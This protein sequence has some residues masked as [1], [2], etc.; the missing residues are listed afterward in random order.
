M[1]HTAAAAA[2]MVG[3]GLMPSAAEAFCGHYVGGDLTNAESQMIVS[4]EGRRTVLTMANDVQGDLTDFGLIVPVPP[5]VTAEDISVVDPAVLDA[6]DV[7]SAPRLVSYS[8]D[9]IAWVPDGE[10]GWDASAP[11][12]PSS[13]V[14]C[15]GGGSTTS[16]TTIQHDTG[17]S[18]DS[19]GG[20][21]EGGGLGE[22]TLEE[23]LR[24]ERFTVG[25]YD[26]AVVEASGS[27]GLSAWLTEAGFALTDEAQVL[28][29]D[30]IAEEM[31]FLVA[32]VSLD[33]LPADRPWLSPLQIRYEADVVSIPIRLGTLS[34]AGVQD[35]LIYTLSGTG[36][37]G[38]STYPEFSV[39]HECLL[40]PVT[41][42]GEFI[43]EQ[44]DIALGYTDTSEGDTGAEPDPEPRAGAGYVTEYGWG[45]GKCDPCP[46]E[47]GV[48]EDVL[49]TLG[50][51]GGVES[52]WVT[53][54]HMRYR[55]EDITADLVLYE[56]GL[57]SLMQLRYVDYAHELEDYWPVCGEG[58][59][60]DPG[61]CQPPD[62]P[63]P[64]YE[65]V[66]DE[67]DRYYDEDDYDEDD[68]GGGYLCAS[69]VVFNP[70]VAM[71]LFGALRRRYGQPQ[72]TDS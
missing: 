18:G 23:V 3:M 58:W 47:G 49:L 60:D 37:M 70:L 55:P 25:E 33:S 13:G 34:S 15:G 59:V 71:L 63:S 46:P 62:E 54:M 2:M 65:D 26:L 72:D 39:E 19:D 28:L 53:R 9:D 11:S 68:G 12:G 43:G 41:S 67:V 29:G 40:P 66:E 6:L 20:H 17:S 44:I 52:A 42:V 50:F 45:Q 21:Y 48:T 61:S 16:T 5:S 35:V 22:A 38:I 36:T 24:V 51:E 64:T 14:G 56:S 7:Y 27:A 32:R 1:R 8:C 69:T 57:Q 31:S 30:Y 10:G 4:R